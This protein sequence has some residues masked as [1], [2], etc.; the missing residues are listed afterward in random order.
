MNLH[1]ES[2]K[3]ELNLKKITVNILVL[4]LQII[5]VVLLA[6][7]IIHF[8]LER[9]TIYEDSMSPTLEKEDKILINKFAYR[10]G[11]PKRSDV[12]V[13][14]QKTKEHSFY[15]IKRIIAIPGDTIQI[16]EDGIYVN[17]KKIKEK[18]EVEEMLNFGLGKELITLEENEYF[19]LGDNR[20]NSEDSR[21]AN[22]GNII[23]DDIVG[24]AW[25]RINDFNFI[26]KLNIKEEVEV[27]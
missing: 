4:I 27:E 24:K 12:I 7:I 3:K 18:I 25:I 20:N 13:F 26:N 1:F 11:K 9:T 23:F 14:K 5:A 8:A 10:F 22:V 6:Y 16:K 15:S 21:F 2:E 19:V 17:N